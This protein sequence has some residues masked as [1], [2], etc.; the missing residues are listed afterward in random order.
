MSKN[1]LVHHFNFRNTVCSCSWF[2]NSKFYGKSKDFETH[3]AS[4]NLVFQPHL[5]DISTAITLQMKLIKLWEDNISFRLKKNITWNFEKRNQ[6]LWS[7]PAFT[8]TPSL[9]ILV[10]HF[11]PTRDEWKRLFYTSTLQFRY[12]NSHNTQFH[13]TIKLADTH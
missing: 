4:S 7:P 10:N 3:E 1:N 11:N 6:L 8:G 5:V 2:I 9:V 13:Y 12:T